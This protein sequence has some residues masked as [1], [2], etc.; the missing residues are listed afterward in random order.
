MDCGT[1]LDVEPGRECDQQGYQSIGGSLM[2]AAL[3]PDQISHSAFR[4]KADTILKLHVRAHMIAAVQCLRHLKGAS[5]FCRSYQIDS[6][7][8]N[9]QFIGYTDSGWAGDTKERKSTGAYVFTMGGA[10]ILWQSKKQEVIAV[11]TQ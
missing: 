7:R 8:L 3:V 4:A 11:S 5:K 9:T 2:Y 6:E 1:N 10:A